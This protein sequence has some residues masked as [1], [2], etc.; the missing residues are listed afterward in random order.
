[1]SLFQSD[2]DR[3]IYVMENYADLILGFLKSETAY[4]NFWVLMLSGHNEKG[5]ILTIV[6]LYFWL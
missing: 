5:V 4:E 2:I 1:M 3:F 6:F